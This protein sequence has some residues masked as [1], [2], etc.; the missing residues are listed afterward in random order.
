MI[1]RDPSAILRC[2]RFLV[3]RPRPKGVRNK[4]E[5]RNVG[6][7]K[8]YASRADYDSDLAKHKNEKAQY[9]LN[10]K[11]W[12][13]QEDRLRDRSGRKKKSGAQNRREAAEAKESEREGRL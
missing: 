13:A 9:E 10:Y 12:R 5:L 3:M 2:S 8:A 11:E 7:D 6:P 4:P 1:F